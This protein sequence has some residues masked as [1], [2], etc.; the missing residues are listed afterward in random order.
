M[1][2]LGHILNITW[3][4]LFNIPNFSVPKPAKKPPMGAR[5]TKTRK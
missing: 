3:D 1:L 2:I 4:W 5:E